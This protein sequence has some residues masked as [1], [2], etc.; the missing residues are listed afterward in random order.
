MDTTLA[1]SLYQTISVTSEKQILE[2]FPNVT[3]ASEILLVIPATSDSVERLN[4]VLKHSRNR[5]RNRM[6]KPRLN[7]L[8]IVHVHK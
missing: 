4:S 1:K 5:Y 6:N 2:I 8:T 3:R 7:V